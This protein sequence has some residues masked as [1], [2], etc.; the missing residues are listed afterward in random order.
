MEVECSELTEILDIVNFCEQV[1]HCDGATELEDSYSETYDYN[2]SSHTDDVFMDSDVLSVSELEESLDEEEISDHESDNLDILQCFINII[3][4]DCLLNSQTDDAQTDDTQ[5][6]DKQLKRRRKRWGVH[7]V[8]QLRKELGHFENLVQEMLMNDHDKFFNYTRM[9]PV[10]F[11]H[12]L[13]LVQPKITKLAPNAIPAKFRLLLTLR[14][15]LNSILI[16]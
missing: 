10:I 6:D 9:S 5:T 3:E 15:V 11:D 14:C 12:L 1:L 4:L 7:P 13:S 16:L 8:N 2:N